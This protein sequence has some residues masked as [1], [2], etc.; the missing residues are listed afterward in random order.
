MIRIST[1]AY[2][3]PSAPSTHSESGP[4]ASTL[5]FLRQFARC[6]SPALGGMVLN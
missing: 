5:S 2:S 6:Y 1:S 4:K 3:A